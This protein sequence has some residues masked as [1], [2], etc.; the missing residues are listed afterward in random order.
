MTKMFSSFLSFFF[1]TSVAWA[2][3]QSMVIEGQ[4][5]EDATGLV[6]VEASSVSIVLQVL[7]PAPSECSLYEET[8]T[9]NMSGSG[10]FFS[11]S[12]GSGVQS[13]GD[14]EDVNSFSDAFNNSIGLVT[15]THCAVGPNYTPAFADGRQ[16]RISYDSGSG[17]QTLTQDIQFGSTP[18]ALSAASVDGLA[19]T[20]LLQINN[21][22][23]FVLTQ[24]NLEWI[25]ANT[26]RYS[27]LQALL[28]GTSTQYSSSVPATDVSM[29]SQKIIDVATPTLATDAAN[30]QY[31][32]GNIAGQ[33][34][35]TATLSG[36]TAGNAGEVMVWNGTQW[37][38]SAPA[39]DSTRL[40]LA[41]GTMTGA[42]DMGIQD[43][44]NANNITAASVN[45]NSLAVSNGGNYMGFQAPPGAV[46][47]LWTLPSTDGTNGQILSTDGV[48]NLFWTSAGGGGEVN[49]AS[50]SGLGGVGVFSAKIGADLEFRSINDDGSGKIVVVNDGANSEIDLTV[51][52]S[53]LDSSAIPNTAA[54][55]IA[56][57]NVQA[58]INELD[59]EKVAIAGDAMTGALT[60]NAQNEIRFA[61]ADSSNYVGFVSP[62][63]VTADFVWTLPAVDGTSGQVLQTNG[64]GVLSWAT[65]GGGG[66]FLADGSVAMTGPMQ[67]Q[68]GTSTMPS[69]TFA[70]DT[71]TGLFQAGPD[72]LQFVTA[73]T[74]RFVIDPAGNVGINIATPNSTF[75]VAGDIQI[76]NESAVCV[77]AKSGAL[78]YNAGFI[79][80]CNGSTWSSLA[81]SASVGDF[82]S[83]GTMPMFGNL[84]MNGY[85]LSNDGASNG[86]YV[87]VGGNVGLGT[88][89][90]AVELD[91]DAGTINAAN[92]CDENNAN[93]LD[94][95]AGVGGGG[96]FLADGSVAMTGPMQAQAG[97]SAMPSYTFDA[98]T[99]TG[100]FQ[101]SPSEIAFATAGTER[102]R[103]NA[104]GRLG[105]G[106]Q[107]PNASLDIM[108]VVGIKPISVRDDIGRPLFVANQF[109]NIGIGHMGDT[110]TQD[111]VS[112]GNPMGRPDLLK[113][114][115]DWNNQP[116]FRFTDRGDFHM[117]SEGQNISLN[118]TSFGNSPRIL[119]T[120]G[121]GTQIAPA[122]IGPG[123]D[124]L[125][126][127]GRGHFESGP[128]TLEGARIR[129]SSLNSWNP[130]D[131]SADMGFFVTPRGSTS[132]VEMLRLDP[133]ASAGG[134][135]PRVLVSGTL[136]L[137]N[138]GAVDQSSCS[139]EF[140]IGDLSRNSSGELL[141]CDGTLWKEVG[142]SSPKPA[143]INA[144]PS[145]FDMSQSLVASTTGDCGSFQFDNMQDGE[146]YKFFVQG[147]SAGQ[148]TFSFF[149]GVGTG[150]LTPNSPASWE[151]KGA[152]NKRLYRFL[153]V[154]PS[155][156][157]VT[158]TDIAP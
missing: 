147:L 106:T 46:D 150:T 81:D 137:N 87:A 2:G 98:D 63:F 113:M 125:R 158:Y 115:S 17:L 114:F 89:T 25:F 32:D 67:A 96:D 97:T 42:I 100:L 29:N 44:L 119:A 108:G 142:E 13:G 88:N 145:T 12:L 18:Y 84:R 91:I 15:P 85:W 130:T 134:E 53:S 152:A 40:P 132:P 50:N 8:H 75:E 139:P 35:D 122:A 73:G 14:Y 144:G 126:I 78:R 5:F 79:E 112:I 6:P 103:V 109:S 148:C 69:Y 107:S 28:N 34:S 127:S 55:N 83:D 26:A 138:F 47:L 133:G 155:D 3:P 99:S 9:L 57:A 10:G 149:S 121:A 24:A 38:A 4:L 39:G 72:S 22:G 136:H 51:D 116:V 61:D 21:G 102:L 68:A 16:L 151:N 1:L 64:S 90:P 92:I 80:Y 157:V 156:V 94:L 37:T 56:A 143:I 66:D 54:G 77:A 52:E 135:Q 7:S 30:K 117:T 93:C 154:G 43:L 20:D 36:L 101:P 124:L 128:S 146:E 45:T 95:S 58:A 65:A 110:G 71:N 131:S 60:L 59:S 74:E 118:M 62:A 153:V 41:G 23:S 33:A 76:G 105:I 49:T 70:G 129:M 141:T 123:I 27:E 104:S 120:A 19:S 86:V 82:R 11:L 140:Q 31:V 111:A 48:G